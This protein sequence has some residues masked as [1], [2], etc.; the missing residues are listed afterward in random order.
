MSFI[1][2]QIYIYF[3][4]HIIKRLIVLSDNYEHFFCKYMCN[5]FGYSRVNKPYFHFFFAEFIRDF[6]IMD[7]VYVGVIIIALTCYGSHLGYKKKTGGAMHYVQEKSNISPIRL[8]K[9]FL[10]ICQFK[11]ERPTEVMTYDLFRLHFTL[12]YL[13]Q[14]HMS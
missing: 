3:S 7:P 12:P 10:I 14:C 8:N 4:V 1:D 2:L 6:S 11:F 5:C 9:Y 13:D